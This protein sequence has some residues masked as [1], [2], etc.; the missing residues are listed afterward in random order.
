MHS[1]QCLDLLVY[2]AA[3]VSTAG[4][5]RDIECSPT[6]PSVGR[7]V[8]RHSIPS[9]EHDNIVAQS[10]APLRDGQIVARVAQ[11][12]QPGNACIDIGCIDTTFGQLKTKTKAVESKTAAVPAADMAS[13]SEP[14][15]VAAASSADAVMLDGDNVS[16]SA[17]SPSSG[18]PQA[19]QGNEVGATLPP[20]AASNALS[21]KVTSSANSLNES[22]RVSGLTGVLTALIVIAILLSAFILRRNKALGITTNYQRA[23]GKK[24][25]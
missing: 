3:L 21:P 8:W 12:R 17:A 9:Y 16:A 4:L 11:W 2:I 14:A 7:V 5:A 24:R 18:A 25:R 1:R 10:Q 22:S 6:R 15:P 19:R 13:A 20:P 23:R